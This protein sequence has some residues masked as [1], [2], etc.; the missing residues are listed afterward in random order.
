MVTAMQKA[1]HDTA[2]HLMTAR[3]ELQLSL[4]SICWDDGPPQSLYDAITAID[5][6]LGKLLP[7]KPA[8][9]LSL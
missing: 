6:L 7:N 1:R 4:S 9:P 3:M 2:A 8:S 5:G